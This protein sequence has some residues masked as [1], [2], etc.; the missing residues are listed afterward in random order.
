MFLE[1]GEQASAAY[2]DFWATLN[3]GEYATGEYRRIGKD[4]REV[5]IHGS[6][7]PILDDTGKPFKVVKYATDVTEQKLRNAD[8]AS[9]I[10]AIGTSQAVIEFEMDGTII[11]ANEN[12][13]STMGY[14]LDEI[15]GRHHRLFVEPETSAQ[16]RV[17]RQF[18]ESFKRGEFTQAEFKRIGKDGRDLVDSRFVHSDSRPQR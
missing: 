9:Q 6:Y 17:S 18:W 3:R 5:W 14:T 11:T 2:R 4:G 1:P 15:K 12:F 16:R 7:N 13:L 8:Y 10:A